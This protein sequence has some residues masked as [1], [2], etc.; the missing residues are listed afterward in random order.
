MSHGPQFFQTIL[1][2]R[3]FEGDF[4]R[5]VKSLERIAKS[6]EEG[7]LG[8]SSP[9]TA[10]PDKVQSV[11]EGDPMTTIYVAKGFMEHPVFKSEAWRALD[12]VGHGCEM[13]LL[14][15][16]ALHA[17]KADEL[18]ATLAPDG[19]YDGVFV[20]DVAWPLGDWLAKTVAET[21]SFPSGAEIEAYTRQ[22]IQR[23]LSV[24]VSLPVSRDLL[25][26]LEA[27]LAYG[28]AQGDPKAQREG[29]EPLAKLRALTGDDCK[30]LRKSLEQAHS[31]LG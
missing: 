13:D 18:Y 7:A 24:Q 27:L 30:A 31:V 23:G 8:H 17:Q 3:F 15:Q 11:V 5:M 9:A 4:P 2:R 22:A 25:G 19:E 12:G 1:G 26:V 29:E 14:E 20:D 16:V 21:G 28:E 6:L 10:A